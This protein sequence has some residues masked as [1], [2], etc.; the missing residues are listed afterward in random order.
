MKR[1]IPVL[2]IAALAV[3][4]KKKEENQA[5]TPAP[6]EQ[7]APKPVEPTPEPQPEA[8][9]PTAADFEVE[10]NE[11]ITDENLEKELSAIEAEIGK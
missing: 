11:Q 10:A 2:F 7:P 3:G 1:I 4:C 8:D 5:P 9:L 6:T